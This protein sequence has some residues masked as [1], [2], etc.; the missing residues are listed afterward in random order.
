[1]TAG[2]DL[3]ARPG[4]ELF[5]RKQGLATYEFLHFVGR[6][7]NTCI[8]PPLSITV[9]GLEFPVRIAAAQKVIERELFLLCSQRACYHQH[10]RQ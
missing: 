8:S 3:L 9:L 10:G 7:L 2:C 5:N 4:V 6:G 1:M